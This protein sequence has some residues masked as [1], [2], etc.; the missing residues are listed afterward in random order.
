MSSNKKKGNFPRSAAKASAKRPRKEVVVVQCPTA[1]P[2]LV[3]GVASK[4][5]QERRRPKRDKGLDWNDTAR[6]IHKFGATAFEGKQKRTYQDEEYERLTG[7]KK[8]HHSIPLPIVR[9][10]RKAAAKREERRLEE[11][12]AAG[13]VIPTKAKKNKERDRVSDIHG[14]APSVGFM[15]HGML[16]VK[17]KR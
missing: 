11:A 6:E 4:P 12:R 2:T 14:P 5:R 16:K 1:F 8:Q 17:T 9:G 7:R 3:S 15:K 13:L 10:L